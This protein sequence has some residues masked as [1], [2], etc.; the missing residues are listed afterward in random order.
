M[1]QVK[2]RAQYAVFNHFTFFKPISLIDLFSTVM[3]YKQKCKSLKFLLD[4][5][6]FFSSFEIGLHVKMTMKRPPTMCI[7]KYCCLLKRIRITTYVTKL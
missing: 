2:V 6:F 1:Q 3:P 5:S 7:Q 4:H